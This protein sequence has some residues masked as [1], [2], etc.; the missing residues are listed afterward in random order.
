MVS[1]GTPE[2][3]HKLLVHLGVDAA[4]QEFVYADPD[5]A[6]YDE[7]DLNRSFMTPAT[8][9]AF[10][11]RIFGGRMGELYEALGKWKDAFY[12]PPQRAQAFNQGATFVLWNGN[13]N[14]DDESQ[15]QQTQPRVVFAH[16]DEAVGA[17]AEHDFVIKLAMDEAAQ[18]SVVATAQ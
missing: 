15:S 9:F 2:V 14:D 4:G 11:D 8:A 17:H 6:T 7:L 18:Q 1:I 3:G 10:R 13:G 5:N 12:I 16:Y